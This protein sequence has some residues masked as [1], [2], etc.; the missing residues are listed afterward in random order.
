MAERNAR[1]LIRQGLNI[2]RDSP[3]AEKVTFAEFDKNVNLNCTT[4]KLWAL[5]GVSFWVFDGKIAIE[6]IVCIVG[7]RWKDVSRKN[8]FQYDLP[9]KIARMLCLTN[10]DQKKIETMVFCKQVNLSSQHNPLQMD[11]RD[12]RPFTV[13]A[14]GTLKLTPQSQGAHQASR[15]LLVQ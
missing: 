8:S 1:S 15:V 13:V 6:S 2:P 3:A 4:P 11:V 7:S 9:A 14:K 10:A 12:L 5:N